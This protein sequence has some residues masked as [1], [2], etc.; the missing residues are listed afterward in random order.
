[1]KIKGL[2]ETDIQVV[3]AF[4]DSNMRPS[5]AAKKTFLCRNSILYHLAR[6]KQK[7]GLDPF[8]FYDLVELMNI[9]YDDE[10]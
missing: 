3:I 10:E 5:V 1:M 8:Q 4:A 2:S 9:F 6:V 7:T